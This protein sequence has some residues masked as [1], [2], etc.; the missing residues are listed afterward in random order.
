[1]KDVFNLNSAGHQM[2]V[3]HKTEMWEFEIVA[4]VADLAANLMLVDIF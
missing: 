2:Y 1:M 4:I 3:R